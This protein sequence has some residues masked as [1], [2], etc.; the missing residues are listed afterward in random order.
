MLATE[1]GAKGLALSYLAA[2]ITAVIAYYGVSQVLLSN[3]E[4]HLKDEGIE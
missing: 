2:W 3:P 4:R 1:Y